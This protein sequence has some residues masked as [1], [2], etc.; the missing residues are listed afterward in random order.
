MAF[1]YGHG[2]SSLKLNLNYVMDCVAVSIF[3]A[4]FSH[5]NILNTFNTALLALTIAQDVY[6][7][8]NDLLVSFVERNSF[9]GA[10]HN[11][12]NT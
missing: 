3:K 6:V 10:T 5:D 9:D 11:K 8:N 7:F 2:L 12:S 1:K 4:S